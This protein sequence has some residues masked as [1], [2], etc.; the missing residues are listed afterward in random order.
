MTLALFAAS[1]LG[2]MALGMPVA[3]ALLVSSLVMM[4]ASGGI[5]TQAVAL[6]MINSA[7][8]F[9]LLAIPFFLLAGEAMSGGGLSRRLVGFALALVGH[10]RGGLG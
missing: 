2:A 8:S 6:Q 7:D 9:A 3:F 1:L 4:L 10:R 5:D